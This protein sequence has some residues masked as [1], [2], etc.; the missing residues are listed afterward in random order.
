MSSARW[1]SELTQFLQKEGWRPAPVREPSA[2]LMFYK[3][4]DGLLLTL[5]I[6]TS[7]R[8]RDTITA[9][10]Y[11]GQTFSWPLLGGDIP[12]ASYARI[13][14]FLR[15]DEYSDLSLPP[16]PSAE[17]IDVWWTGYYPRTLDGFVEAIRRALPR[18]LA[19]PGLADGA[20]NSRTMQKR[21]Q[22]VSK[23]RENA[24]QVVAG[25]APPPKVKVN[26]AVPMHWYS[27]AARILGDDATTDRIKWVTEDAWNYEHA[28]E[29][30]NF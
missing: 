22:Q 16:P 6:E 2:R 25:E 19:Q 23:V 21:L 15:H 28:V 14:R 26:S 18:F 10:F 24:R 13:G 3:W 20:R 5:A 17:L 8:H 4:V 29:A 9:S 11:L 7:K 1:F 30:Q 12:G 27:V